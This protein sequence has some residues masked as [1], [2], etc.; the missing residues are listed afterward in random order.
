VPADGHAP[1]LSRGPLPR[2]VLEV[3]ERLG[4]A[5]YRAWVVGGSVRDSLLDQIFA[6]A[7]AETWRAKDW[8]LA[9]DATPEQVQP[10]FRRVIPTGIDHGTVTVLLH[11]Q[12]LELT[13]LRAERDYRDGR[14][15]EHVDF[16]RS[17]EEDLARRDFTVNA[18]AFEP[19]T[20]TLVD[21]FDGV[22][23]LRARRLRA[24]GEA[25]R[26]FAED[27]LRVLRAA[28]LVATLEFE[29]DPDTA[30][31]I[32]PSLDTYRRVSAERI[33]DEWNK[34]LLAREP[35]RAFR[36]M[37]EHGM[38]AITAPELEGLAPRAPADTEGGP[39]G[40][41]VLAL[42]RMDRCAREVELRLAALLRDVHAEPGRSAEMADALLV[43]LRYS[44]AERKLIGHLIRNPLPPRHELATEASV[45]RWLRCI[46]PE[47]H[48]AA[49]QLERARLL[50]LGAAD[51]ELQ[52]VEEIEQRAAAELAKNPPL[53]LSALAIDGKRLMSDAGL[54]PGRQIGVI[55]EALLERVLDDPG[56]NEPERL[57]AHAKA[58]A[59]ASNPAP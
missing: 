36:V 25:A 4:S 11:G 56:E 52:A 3:C 42:S 49:C 29:L 47:L 12:E 8:D 45:R 34:A 40:A 9:T 37:H 51:A 14:R 19:N 22:S 35:S 16:V 20:E 55:L 26:R 38:L 50:A 6:G 32:A 58:L 7:P 17:I 28:R 46:G 48:P 5:G 33:R 1:R 21:P 2:A 54:R 41:L 23:D 15:P 13:T 10:L 30:R 57:L 24:V 43:R 27:G 18:I 31:A 59:A 53:S 44:N 39:Q